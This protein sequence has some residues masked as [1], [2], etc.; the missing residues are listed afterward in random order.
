ME[1]KKQLEDINSQIVDKEKEYSS[2]EKKVS[3]FLEAEKPIK[4][5]LAIIRQESK[6]ILTLRGGE[7][8][9]RISGKNL[10]KLM[11]MEQGNGTLRNIT[12]AYEKNNFSE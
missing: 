2:Y 7:P 4:S 5:E 3:I 10:T 1:S 12:M 11:E 6:Q 8:S 9:Y